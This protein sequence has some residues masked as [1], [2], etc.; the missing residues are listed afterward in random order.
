MAAYI[1]TGL[2][3]REHVTSEDEGAFNAGIVGTGR[4]VMKTAEKFAAEIVSNNIVRIKS[5]D[6]V[7]QGR[8]IRTEVNDYDDMTI[9]N[10]TQS[11]KRNDLIVM[12]Y[13]KDTSTNIELE[14]AELVVIKGT[15][16]ATAT[17]PT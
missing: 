13:K 15:A 14:S 8:H 11:L 16:G 10:G 6:L 2:Q 9:E 3:G 1:V 17:D 12:R 4:Y 5:G 7:N